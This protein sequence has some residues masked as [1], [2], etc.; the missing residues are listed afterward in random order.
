MKSK[1]QKIIKII[2]SLILLTFIFYTNLPA[3]RI[4]DKIVAIVDNEIIT[5]SELEFQTNLFAAQRNITAVDD[6]L[7][8]QILNQMIESKLLYAQ[9]ELDSIIVTEDE[10]DGRLDMQLDYFIKQYGS[11]E[12]V[13]EVYGMSIEKI[14]REL[15]DEVRKNLMV[16]RVQETKFGAIEAKRRDIEMFFEN[17]K[18]S[19]GLIPEKVTISHIFVNPKA[20]DRVKKKYYD[21][22]KSLRDSI[23]AG[24][25]FSALAI[26]YS[27]DPGSAAQGGDLGFVQRGVFYPEFEAVAF[28]LSPNELSN[29]V[30]SPVGYH[31]I[32]LLERRGES[33]KTRHILI[34]IKGDSED[35]LKTIEFLS[36][37]RDSIISNANTFAYYAEKYSDD[38][39]TSNFGGTIGTFELGQL[40]KNLLDAIGTL[41]EGNIS[42]PKRIQVDQTTYGYHIVR[43]DKRSPEHVPTLETDYQEIKQLA[44]FQKKQEYYKNWI[45]EIKEK[46]YWEIRL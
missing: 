16:Q 40:D 4:V 29:I 46:I 31:I 42:F 2:F 11:R 25:D 12:K 19:L 38:K 7:K 21:L 23:L 33:I 37:I 35:D 39:Q 10:V 30:E 28:S 41:K 44:D 5:K 43:L 27:E 3:Q 18:D 9:A 17:N 24:A 1:F 13:E 15:R 14:K 22:A 8:S 6:N 34:K 32:Q 20:S 26:K 36:D 45:V